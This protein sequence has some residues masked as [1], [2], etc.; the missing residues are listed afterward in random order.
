MNLLCCLKWLYLLL[1]L[2]CLCDFSVIC[3]VGIWNILCVVDSSLLWWWC[4]L[5]LGIVVGVVYFCMCRNV[6]CVLV[7]F[8]QMLI[9][10]VYLGRFVLYMWQQV[11]VLWVC[12]FLNF[13]MFLCRWLVIICVFLFSLCG[14]LVLLCCGIVIGLQMISVYLIVLLN[15]WYFLLVCRLVVNVRLVLLYRRLV[16]YCGIVCLSVLLSW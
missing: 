7:F 14:W 3:L 10:V 11:I 8:L 1:F 6:W 2:L 5:I 9:V 13:L 16:C 4:I 12:Q 15:S